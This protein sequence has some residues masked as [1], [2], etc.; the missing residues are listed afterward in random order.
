M[1]WNVIVTVTERGYPVVRRLLQEYGRIEK[2]GFFNVLVMWVDDKEAFLEAMRT[3]YAAPPPELIYIGRIIPLTH[4]FR[5]QTAAE[6]EERAREVVSL[7][8][9]E[10]AGCHFY[11]RMHRRGFKGRLSSQQEETFL[12]HYLLEELASR[13]KAA[14][15]V[16]FAGAE[17]VIAVETLGQW[18]GFSLWTREEIE[19]YPFLKLN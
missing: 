17:R 10:L 19:R 16:D 4:H 8:L 13:G 9:D 14:A 6:F 11:V 12:D 3:L 18:A 15:R 2:S 5:Y 7:W 1:E